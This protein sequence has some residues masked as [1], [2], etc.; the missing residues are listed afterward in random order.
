MHAGNE[1]VVRRAP[2]DDVGENQQLRVRPGGEPA[3]LQVGR[4]KGA[5]VTIGRVSALRLADRLS[6]DRMH[7]HIDSLG[8]SHEFVARTRVT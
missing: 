2:S 6:L 7:Q 1:L 8:L 3:Q 5:H 4:V